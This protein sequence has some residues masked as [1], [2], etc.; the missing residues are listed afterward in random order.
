MQICMVLFLTIVL[1]SANFFL[2]CVIVATGVVVAAKFSPVWLAG[3]LVLLGVAG[4]LEQVMLLTCGSVK[5]KV[6]KC[7]GESV[8]NPGNACTV[9]P[10]PHS[11]AD[12]RRSK[13]SSV[14]V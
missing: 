1:Q 9:R 3:L 14:W 7:H 10:C 12:L 4:C 2:V 13:L 8:S 6:W 11:F 5:A